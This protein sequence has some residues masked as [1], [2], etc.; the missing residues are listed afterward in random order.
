MVVRKGGHCLL[1]VVMVMVVVNGW[2]LVV[3]SGGC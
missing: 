3:G 2:V 1:M